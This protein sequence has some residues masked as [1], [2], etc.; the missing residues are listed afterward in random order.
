MLEI[1][2]E[3]AEENRR[4]PSQ[5]GQL[6]NVNLVDLDPRE[7]FAPDSLTLIGDLKK[8]NFRIGIKVRGQ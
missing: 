8:V 3:D 6:V 5:G 7:D 4:R 1:Q 2:P